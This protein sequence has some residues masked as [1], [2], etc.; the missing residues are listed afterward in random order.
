MIFSFNLHKQFFRLVS[1]KFCLSIAIPAIGAALEAAMT[2]AMTAISK[3]A[4]F[5]FLWEK[6][7]NDLE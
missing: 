4:Q 5:I 2:A 7:Q 6:N 3:T 1:P